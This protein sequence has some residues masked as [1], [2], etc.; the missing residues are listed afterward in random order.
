MEGGSPGRRLDAFVASHVDAP[1][2]EV[3]GLPRVVAPLPTWLE[4]VAFRLVWLVVAVN[5]L[6]TAFGIFYYVPQLSATPPVMWPVVPASP[7][8]TLYVAVS[9]SCWRLGYDGRL[10]QLVHVLAFLGCLKYGLWSVYVQLFVE[11][12]GV[13][14]FLLWQF[15]VWSHAGMALQAFLI[16]RY[17]EFPLW[18]LS[19]AVGWYVLNDVLDYFVAVFGGPHH[20]WLNVLLV[21]GH[22]DRSVPAFELMA[23]SAVAATVLA[24]ALAVTT[25]WWL[26]TTTGR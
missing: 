15:L 2:P 6:G 13:T 4:N 19:V 9:L 11:D 25:W 7:L 16:P 20:T 5:L 1:V 26:R 10:A 24:T 17:A 14:P 21:D 22:I 12:A 8:A 23:V 18:T 3:R